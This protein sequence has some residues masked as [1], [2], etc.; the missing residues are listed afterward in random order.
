MGVG[1]EYRILPFRGRY[2]KLKPEAAS[3]IRGL[4]YPVPDPR[5]PFLGVHLTKSIT[6][7]V[8]VGPTAEP[9]L[10]R[11]NY[12]GL[13]GIVWSE[14]PHLL[15]DLSLMT[16]G[17]ASG[18]AVHIWEEIKKKLPGGLL[19]AAQELVPSLKR[20][21]LTG[22]F[23]SGLRAQLVDIRRH[24]L[25]MDFVVERGP[26]STHILNAVSP[27]FTASFAFAAHVADF[28]LDATRHPG[29][30]LG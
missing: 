24:R 11:E 12:A 19:A 3:R 21:D 17:N 5:L 25:V 23:K 22:E 16:L 14:L 8:W 18:L 4:I 9:A 2:R 26:H 29:H 1:D 30:F 10:G 13:S 20:S 27:G 6:G 28:A 7:E 15:M